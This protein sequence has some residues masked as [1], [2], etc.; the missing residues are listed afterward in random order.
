MK[1]LIEEVGID[2][3]DPDI[4]KLLEKKKDDKMKP[5]IDSNFDLVYLYN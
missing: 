1:E 4:K 5:R 2:K 3:E